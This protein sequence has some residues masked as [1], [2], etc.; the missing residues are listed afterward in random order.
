MDAI[1]NTSI[2]ANPVL[3]FAT[4]AT[5]PEGAHAPSGAGR[6][7]KILIN[8]EHRAR[9]RLSFLALILVTAGALPA[10]AHA[11]PFT[12][13]DDSRVLERLPT[14][15]DTGKRELRRLRARLSAEP[16]DLELAVDLAR[17][18]I[19]FGRAESDPRYNGYAQAALAPWWQMENA[20]VDVLVLRATLL[21]NRHQFDAALSDLSRALT[22]DPRNPQAWLTHAVILQVQ[23][24]ASEAVA[25]CLRLEGIA[26]ALVRTACLGAA[27]GRAGRAMAAYRLLDRAL[28]RKPNAD[29]RVRVWVSTILAEIAVSLDRQ[30]DA[31]RHFREAR[32]VKIRDA[33]LL[34]AYAD[35]LLDQG[36]EREV[37]SLLLDEIRIDG[38]LLRLALAE[39]RLDSARTREHVLALRARFDASRRR[40][41]SVHLRD[42]ARFELHLLERPER[43]LKFAL[44][45]WRSQREPWDA[46]LVLEAALAADSPG[47][48]APVIDW[49]Y[50]TGLEDA[51]IEKLVRSLSASSS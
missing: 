31:E 34:N 46:R 4:E 3:I 2:A 50:Q 1:V 7:C 48:A 36:R 20:P 8:G 51:R 12:P 28:R 5:G 10:P 32:N 41:D 33:Y 49:F 27:A 22:L 23:G 14:P 18:Y 47:E 19:Q 13:V 38:L 9:R 11:E 43:A 40:G 6:D 17:R 24:K 30:Q 25:S 21:Q 44:A 45:N 15:G 35:F 29:P 37:V 26:D 16:H 39:H 42:E